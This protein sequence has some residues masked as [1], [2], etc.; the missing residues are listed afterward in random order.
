MLTYT[1]VI[2]T[3]KLSIATPIHTILID[4][5]HKSYKASD[6]YHNALFCNKNVHTCANF[7]YKL[8][9]YK[10]VH[11]GIWVGALWDLCNWSNK[12]A[13][14]PYHKFGT[15]LLSPCGFFRYVDHITSVLF[16]KSEAIWASIKLL[17]VYHFSA[18]RR[19]RFP[20]NISSLVKE[21]FC[22]ISGTKP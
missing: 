6:L 22:Y 21:A 10:L 5:S 17:I 15:Q 4:P 8:V 12:A 1:I 13:S 19:I 14:R 16:C 20:W 2:I 11:Y 18:W 7:R 3:T 9:H